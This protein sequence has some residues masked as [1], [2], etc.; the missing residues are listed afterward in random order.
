MERHY[1]ALKKE[2]DKKNSNY[3][4]VNCYLNKE[5]PSRREWLMNILAEE[6]ATKL[7]EVYPCYK[8]HVEVHMQIY[9]SLQ[10]FIIVLFIISGSHKLLVHHINNCYANEIFFDIFNNHYLVV[11]KLRLLKF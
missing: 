10:L 7:L 4:V 11:T 9:I 5:F 8:D 2:M 1:N 6:R 3:K